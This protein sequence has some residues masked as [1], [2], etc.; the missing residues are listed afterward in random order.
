MFFKSSIDFTTNRKQKDWKPRASFTFNHTWLI[1][2]GFM[3]LV[4]RTQK[5]FDRNIEDS[6]MKQFV[7]KRMK[8]VETKWE[9]I[10]DNIH[11]YIQY[12][13]MYVQGGRGYK[14]LF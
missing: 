3:V 5:P 6:T 2:E 7:L 8:M 1:T 9:R 12:V 4:T 10:N 14:G 13:C 11:T